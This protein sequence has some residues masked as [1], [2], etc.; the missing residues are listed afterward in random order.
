MTKTPDTANQG[1][2]PTKCT[3]FSDYQMNF[4]YDKLQAQLKLKKAGEIILLERAIRSWGRARQ[5]EA[6]IE[7][8][9]LIIETINSKTGQK[10]STVNPLLSHQKYEDNNFRAYMKELLATPRE[11]DKAR[12][13]KAKSAEDKMDMASI[14]GGAEE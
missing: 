13:K 9:G 2:K 11:E 3:L 14:M 10:T 6:Y 12:K 8:E 1:K 7:Q 4:L 5:I